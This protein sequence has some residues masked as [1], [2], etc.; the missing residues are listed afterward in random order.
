MAPNYELLKVHGI[1]FSDDLDAAV[2]A[3]AHPETPWERLPFHISESLAAG[4]AGETCKEGWRNKLVWGDNLLVMGSLL[5]QFAGKIDLI[6]IDPP[7][8]TGS[9]FVVATPIGDGELPVA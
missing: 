2:R 9:D 4:K 8:A 7:F 5:E 1:A 6:Y 3:V